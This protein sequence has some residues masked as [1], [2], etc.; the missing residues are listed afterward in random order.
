[1][2]EDPAC[3][4]VCTIADGVMYADEGWGGRLFAAPASAWSFF[5]KG[6]Y[7]IF[8]YVIQHC[9]ICRSSDSTVPEDAG[10]ESNPCRT[11]AT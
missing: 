1:M 10:I 4:Y 5:L 2:K 11:V 7:F 3:K 9:F 6:I 8:M